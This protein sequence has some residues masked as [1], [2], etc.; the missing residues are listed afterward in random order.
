M[1][2]LSSLV[3]G[4]EALNWTALSQVLALSAVVGAGVR[5]L[6]YLWSQRIAGEF[7]K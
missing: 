1:A 5:L 6:L 7:G 3:V 2:A 4:D